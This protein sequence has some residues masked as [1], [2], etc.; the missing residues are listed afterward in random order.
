MTT[1]ASLPL[2][3][4]IG[5]WPHDV[6]WGGLMQ[7]AYQLLYIAGPFFLIGLGLH[8]LEASSQGRLSAR[9]GWKSVLWTG[10]LGTPIHE[11]SHAVVCLLFRHRIERVALF[12]PDPAS[13]RLGY[14]RH[15]FDSKSLYQVVGNFFIGVAPFVGGALALYGLLWLFS[16]GAARQALNPDRIAPA[17]AGGDLLAAGQGL[18]GEMIGVLS[19]V[20]TLQNLGTLPF[21]IFLYFVLCVGSHLAPSPADYR[22]AW[23]G[24]LLLLALLLVFNIGWLALGGPAGAV[25]GMLAAVLAP[26]LALLA[27]AAALNGLTST[28][29]FALTGLVRR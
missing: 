19:G 2:Q 8:K 17:V 13:G 11:F 29:V 28:L 18:L 24:G 15:S 23:M 14:V 16:P 4:T 20:I 9:F 5:N 3:A 27:L 25:T 21:W 22:G 1:P 26:V 7:T 10:W 6:L 12:E